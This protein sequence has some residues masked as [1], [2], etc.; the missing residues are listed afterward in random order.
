MAQQV[1]CSGLRPVH[2]GWLASW[3][4]RW[5]A[6][7]VRPLSRVEPRFPQEALHWGIASGRVR[8]RMTVSAEGEVIRV[9][10]VEAVPR[11]VFDRAVVK[12]LSRWRFERGAEGRR[13]EMDVLFEPRPGGNYGCKGLDIDPMQPPQ[14][15]APTAGSRPRRTTEP[16]PHR[17]TGRDR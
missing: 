11:R 17:H 12:T 6:R 13:L 8:A 14:H 16:P 7:A 5:F 2:P 10:V 1:R 15:S 9:E 3:W 4:S